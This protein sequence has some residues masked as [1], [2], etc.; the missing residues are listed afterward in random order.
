MIGSFYK[1][2]L[3]FMAFN[4]ITFAQ[5]DWV[6]WGAQEVQYQI[7]SDYKITTDNSNY[8]TGSRILSA[9]RSVYSFLISD[10][11][12]D[13]CPFHPSCS[14][15]FVESVNETGLIKGSLMFADRFIRDLNFFKGR[16]EYSVH[17]SGKFFDPSSNYT[18]ISEKIIY[19]PGGLLGK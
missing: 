3:L 13:N 8:G 14:H 17:L 6:K 10:L 9:V 18:L 19:Y 11:D 7:V 15:F 16:G 2:V 4:V 5:T 1:P 12:G